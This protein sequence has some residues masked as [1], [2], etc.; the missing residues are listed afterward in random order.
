M[1]VILRVLKAKLV[2]DLCCL[3]ASKFLRYFCCFGSREEVETIL[4]KFEYQQGGKEFQNPVNSG[5]TIEV[6]SFKQMLL[7]FLALLYNMRESISLA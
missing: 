3:A 6:I 5:S 4:V 2:L 1:N 7:C